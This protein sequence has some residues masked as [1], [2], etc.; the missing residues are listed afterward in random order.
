[1]SSFV[2]SCKSHIDGDRKDGANDEHLEHEVLQG[3]EEQNVEWGLLWQVLVVITEHL[4]PHLEGGGADSRVWG[5]I[6]SFQNG[7]YT[8][9]VV[10][11]VI[12]IFNVLPLT[13]A[14]NGVYKLLLCNLEVCIM[15]CAR[16]IIHH[17]DD[18][19]AIIRHII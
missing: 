17:L 4:V 16:R 3:A 10:L 2:G 5:H 15:G 18:F 9:K 7:I 6:K 1:M 13:V 14:L 12:D 19:T 8:L 11:N